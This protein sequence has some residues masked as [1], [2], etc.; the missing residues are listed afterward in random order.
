M[1]YLEIQNGKEVSK[2]SDFQ[3]DIGSTADFTK[4]VMKATKGCGQLSSNNTLLVVSWFIRVKIEEE[5]NVERVDYYG[6][7]KTS[8]MGFC[9]AMLEKL[10]K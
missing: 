8:H 1:L 5:V 6:P 9:L 3:Q 2:A 10:L 7:V 4:I